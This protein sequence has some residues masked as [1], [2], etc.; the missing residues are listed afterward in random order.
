MIRDKTICAARA[1]WYGLTEPVGVRLGRLRW[2]ASADPLV[3]VYIPTFNR[4]DLLMK[5]ALPSV[6]AQTY[7]N[8]ELVVA[9]HGCT[10]GTADVVWGIGDPRVR[11]IEVPRKR[12]Y[13]PTALNHWLVGPV[14]PAN[15]ALRRLRGNWIARLDDD[16]VWLPNHLDSLVGF[17]L[18]HDYEFASAAHDTP[19][20]K[21]EPYRVRGAT[22]GGT[23]TWVYRSYLKFMRYNPDC[24]RKS[25]NK[26]N[27]IDLQNRFV[28]AGVRI[29]YL[30]EV[31]CH[32]YP[33]PGDTEIG[34]RAYLADEKRTE[35][36]FAF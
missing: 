5:R 26:N 18:A 8:W 4:V 21:V 16:D 22:I 27:D 15:A 32:I 17:A 23:Q 11:L 33:R 19:A 10:D 36:R 34:S 24:W 1:A 6:L 29:G 20:G 35:Q 3:S 2:S 12:T 25:W 31:T 30:D 28:G 9:A 7:R 14:V 13:P